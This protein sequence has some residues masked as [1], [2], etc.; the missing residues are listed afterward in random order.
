MI[1][2]GSRSM[3]EPVTLSTPFVMSRPPPSAVAAPRSAEDGVV[4]R[5]AELRCWGTDARA[6]RSG[7]CGER[8]DG[9]PSRCVSVGARTCTY[10]GLPNCDRPHRIVRIHS[11]V[12][13]ARTRVD[14]T[15]KWRTV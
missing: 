2:G 10:P 13:P 12:D 14:L 15:S 8:S 11:E 3:L 1:W 6:G 4:L 7:P 5:L 9:R